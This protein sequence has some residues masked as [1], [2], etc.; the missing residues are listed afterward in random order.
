MANN[1]MIFN[2]EKL[3]LGLFFCSGFPALIYQLSW[4]RALFR[5]FGV[6]IESVTIVV[7]AFML[8]LGLGSMVGGWLSQKSRLPLLL[9]LAGI[10]LSTAIFGV[11]SLS[12]FQAAGNVALNLPLPI[13]AVVMLVL[14]LVP[15]LLMGATLPVLV[16]FLTQRLGSTGAAVGNLYYAN[17]LGAG[18]ACLIAA[19]VLFPFCG[20]QHT[21]MVAASINGL[22]ALGALVT[23]YYGRQRLI[24]PIVSMT[25][26]RPLPVEPLPGFWAILMLAGLSGFVSLSYEI[27]FFRVMAF[28]SGDSA[29]LFAITLAVFLIGLAVGARLIGMYCAN[30]SQRPSAI[31]MIII[32]VAANLISLLFLPIIARTAIFNNFGL[33]LLL[34]FSQT[35]LSGMILPFLAEISILPDG[36]AGMHTG[37]IYFANIIGSALGGIVTGFIILNYLTL[38]TTSWLLFVLGLFSVYWL[39]QVLAVA[40]RRRVYL[41]LG[42]MGISGLALPVITCLN[43]QTLDR[44]LF[45]RQ[46][47][48]TTQVVAAVENR[49]GII[50]VDKQ[51]R[52]FGNGMYDGCYNTDLVHDTNMIVRAYALSLYHPAPRHVLMIGLSSGSW[53]Q[54]IVNNPQVEHLTVIE[55]NPGYVALI[56]NWPEVASL[57]ANPKFTLIIDDGQRWLK[58][59]QHE[60]FDAIIMNTTWYY[61]ANA[62]NLLAKEFLQ[63]LRSHLHPAGTIFYNTTDSSRAMKTACLTF[64]HGMRFM[65]HMLISE[66][67]LTLDFARWREVL[68]RTKINGRAVLDLHYQQDRQALTRLMQLPQTN[69]L[70][71]CQSILAR[72]NHITEITD[73]NMG[74]EWRYALG[75]E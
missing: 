68:L 63:L 36:Q 21:I 66:A 29:T 51:G 55:I 57:L 40:G 16:G 64:P 62:A 43:Q 27:Y 67:P 2:L 25:A 69:C 32:M 7:T 38:V 42:L 22:V 53:A 33:A 44:L 11:F 13:L 74:S 14:V 6:N 3:L 28:I 5:I 4:Q 50:T 71:S 45:G 41:L 18:I 54:V 26:T 46:F 23:H 10:E 20:I 60:R 30:T 12:L 17:T 48:T 65:N 35:T 72:T 39:A 15:T 8:G 19:L 59:H 58:R 49:S 1:K 24:M 52:V 37:K 31:Q 9:L 73:D 70:E 34:I 75:L 61:R 47:N 56:R